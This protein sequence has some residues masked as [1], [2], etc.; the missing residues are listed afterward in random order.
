MA[1]MVTTL[2]NHL[3]TLLATI[4]C[5]MRKYCLCYKLPCLWKFYVYGNSVKHN[6]KMKEKIV[7]TVNKKKTTLYT[8]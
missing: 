5:A 3:K 8:N 6:K 7:C 4:T 1:F 2:Y